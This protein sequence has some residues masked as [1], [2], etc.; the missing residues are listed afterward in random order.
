[1]A[2]PKPVQLRIELEYSEQV[3][4]L[5][6]TDAKLADILTLCTT[7]HQRE[8]I[9]AAQ[10]VVRNLLVIQRSLW[11]QLLRVQENQREH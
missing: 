4:Q 9:Y 7:R 5:A 3:K 6:E 8:S 1:M 2:V 11:G 10:E